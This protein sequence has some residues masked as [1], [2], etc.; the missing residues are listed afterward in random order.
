MG[1]RPRVLIAE[2]NLA[3]RTLLQHTLEM[4][5]YEVEAVGDG[6]AALDSIRRAKPDCVV[7]DV[8]MPV[9]DGFGVLEGI[10]ADDAT[11]EIPVVMLTALDDPDSTWKGWSGGCHYYMTKPFEPEDLIN[12]VHD[13]TSGVAA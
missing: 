9:L 11:R 1:G 13:L 3:T 6:R 10:R 12:V 5:G 8:M 7:L 2:D 4:E